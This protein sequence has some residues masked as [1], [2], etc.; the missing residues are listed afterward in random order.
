MAKD[1]NVLADGLKFPEGPV[2]DPE[3]RLWLVELEAGSVDRRSADGTLSRYTT[4]GIPNGLACDSCGHIFVCDKTQKILKFDDSCQCFVTLAR[5]VA[6][7]ELAEPN[8]ICFDPAGQL[9]FTC[10][11]GSGKEPVGYLCRMAGES[12]VQV[13]AEGFRYPNGLAFDPSGRRLYVAE[14]GNKRLLVGDY[15][16]DGELVLE[17]FCVLSDT[18]GPDGIALD[19]EGN[20][21]AALFGA[22]EIAVTSPAGEVIERIELPGQKPTNVAFDPSGRL[23]MVVTEAEKGL[24]LSI[25]PAP[26]GLPLLDGCVPA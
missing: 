16:P 18:G 1:I 2:F 20:I 25:T 8:D 3:G 17:E 22:G 26:A 6:G 10:P 21:Y 11:G 4:G 5:E 7:Q 12:K 14:S 23:G 13:I 19:A 9:V 24:L 15:D